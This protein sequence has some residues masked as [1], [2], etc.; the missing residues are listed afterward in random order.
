MRFE[1]GPRSTRESQ[2]SRIDRRGGRAKL[3]TRPGAAVPTRWRSLH[4]P[5]ILGHGTRRQ[6]GTRRTS[7]PVTTQCSSIS[8]GRPNRYV[9]T[10]DPRRTRISG[11]QCRGRQEGR[12]GPQSLIGGS[13]PPRGSKLFWQLKSNPRRED[14]VLNRN[15]RP[16][17]PQLFFLGQHAPPSVRP[18]P[19]PSSGSSSPDMRFVPVFGLMVGPPSLLESRGSVLEE[20]LLPA[21]EDGRLKSPFV[22][23]IRDRHSFHQMPPQNGYFF[24]RRVVLPL[25]LHVFAPL[26]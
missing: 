12:Q 6:T 23:Q 4:W 9:R 17:V 20:L 5:R 8:V 16:A 10:I 1:S 3:L 11:C 22:T 7:E 26:S 25:F 2:L 13:I 19:H 18:K 15:P 14:G 21:V 24:F